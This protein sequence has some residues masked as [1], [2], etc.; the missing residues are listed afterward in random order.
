M[1]EHLDRSKPLW[2]FDV[3]GPLSDGREAIAARI[4]HAMADGI[5]GVHFLDALLFD[6]RV[7]PPAIAPRKAGPACTRHR[8]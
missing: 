2:T 5:A 3:I 1:S 8:S 4:H 7:T 6:S